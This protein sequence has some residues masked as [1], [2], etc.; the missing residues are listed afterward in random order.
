[1]RRVANGDGQPSSKDGLN[2]SPQGDLQ[3]AQADPNGE[4]GTPGAEGGNTGSG[5]TGTSGDLNE[6]NTA[7]KK[8]SQRNWGQLPG[9]LKTEILQGANKR[10]RPEYEKQIKSYFEEI[11]KP[12]AKDPAPK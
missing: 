9:Q 7:L 12:A 3:Q 10:P 11:T 6:L 5:V 8:Q 1:M 2:P 4:P